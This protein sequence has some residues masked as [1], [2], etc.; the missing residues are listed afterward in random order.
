MSS[1]LIWGAGGHA[2]VVADIARWTGWTVVGFVNDQPGGAVCVR[3]GE[4]AVYDRNGAEAMVQRVV[5][6]AVVAIGDPRVRLEKASLL[7]AWGCTFPVLVHPRAVVADT[8]VLGPGTVVCPGAVVA[9]LTRV[10]PF[11]ILNTLA[12]ADHE[13][14]LG[15]AVHLSPGAR[16]GGRVSVGRGT[17][18]G[19]GA[20]V[21][22][23]VRLGEWCY[24]GAGAALVADLPDASLAYGVPAKR[25]G[26]S[27]YALERKSI[28]AA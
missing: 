11:C 27:P 18:I 6:H 5:R 16:L 22:D 4:P 3:K 9:P 15:E 23:G 1:L 17:W 24:V 14:D 26:V 2:A 8:A 13:C 7:E 19:I 28:E 20:C 25:R 10:G 21:R 12:S